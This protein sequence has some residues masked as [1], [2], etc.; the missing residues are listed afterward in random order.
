MRSKLRYLGQGADF[1][2]FAGTL[3]RGVEDDFYAEAVRD[4]TRRGVRSCST[5]RVSRCGS[6]PKPSRT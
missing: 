2:V 3:P 5:P 6:A 1:V 4:L